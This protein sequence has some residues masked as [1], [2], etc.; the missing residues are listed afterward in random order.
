MNNKLV[1][2]IELLFITTNFNY[3]KSGQYN[4]D[5]YWPK[6]KIP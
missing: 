1:I 2:I 3:G 4:N 6:W 5:W